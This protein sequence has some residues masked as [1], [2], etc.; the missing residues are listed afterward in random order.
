MLASEPVDLSNPRA[1]RPIE[2]AA[3]NSQ[4]PH[5]RT[6]P[7]PSSSIHCTEQ[8][9]AFQSGVR[10]LMVGPS[11]ALTSWA[12][13]G[14]EIIGPTSNESAAAPQPQTGAAPAPEEMAVEAAGQ[15]RIWFQSTVRLPHE[16][17]QHFFLTLCWLVFAVHRLSLCLHRILQLSLFQLSILT[18]SR[19]KY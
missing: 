15:E 4:K 5:K 18:E 16:L 1:A 6:F 11:A 17:P 19:A 8:Q 13:L 9:G 7:T 10:T 3:P 14:Y 2:V 12:P